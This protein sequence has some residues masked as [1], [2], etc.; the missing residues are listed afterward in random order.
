MLSRKISWFRCAYANHWFMLRKYHLP[1]VPIC[2]KANR[3]REY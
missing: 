1:T 2:R 3:L